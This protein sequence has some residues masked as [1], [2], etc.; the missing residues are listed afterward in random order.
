MYK[1]YSP[2]RQQNKHKTTRPK[3]RPYSIA[4][5]EIRPYST[6]AKNLIAE[7]RGP[8]ANSD[9]Y[10]LKLNDPNGPE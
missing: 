6:A 1:L 3:I 9:S 4:A 10:K 8:Q 5:T 7:Q 2:H